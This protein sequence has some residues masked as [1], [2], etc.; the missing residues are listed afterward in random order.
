VSQRD[1]V[2]LQDKGKRTV[3]DKEYVSQKSK[4]E[5]GIY[6]ELYINVSSLD[7]GKLNFFNSQ[8]PSTSGGSRSPAELSLVAYRV[9]GD[10]AVELPILGKIRVAGLT[11]DEATKMI[12]QELVNYLNSPTVRIS[13]VN[14][15]V[16]VLGYVRNPGRYY[17]AGEYI[18]VFQAL[19]MA[20]D[21]TDFANRKNVVVIREI[22]NKITKCRMNLT[23]KNILESPYYYLDSND[24]VYVEPMDKR[25]WGVGTFPFALILSSLTTFVLVANYLDN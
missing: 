13:F 5:I 11:I 9:D 7:E 4:N 16:T 23:D 17:Y 24:I 25:K 1:A 2:Y 20:G 12:R 3:F 10:G 18:S 15:N 6:D 21:M 14:R 19:G 8:L 22:N